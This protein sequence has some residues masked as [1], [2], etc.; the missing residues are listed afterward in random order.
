ML[1]FILVGGCDQNKD[2]GKGDGS[3]PGGSYAIYAEFA[4]DA[5]VLMKDG[6]NRRV[7]NT[8]EAQ[9]GADI[10]LEKDGSITLLP[11]TYRMTGFSMVTLQAGLAVPASKLNLSYPG[12]GLV[13]ER[14]FEK[15]DPLRHQIG[16]GSPGT[17]LD[18][19]PSLFDLV[20]TCEKVTQ[21]CVGH[22]S[23]DQLNNE[24]YLSV[25]EVDG[26]KSP[27]H[28]FARVAIFKIAP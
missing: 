8:T 15:N 25:Y 9:R 6:L 13:Y 23:G 12:Y 20:F 11:G 21:I 10:A 7:F 14:D 1:L 5:N 2:A 17:A 16:V 4:R 18:M 26:I 28:V 27:F 3:Q 22:Q 24:V 19:N